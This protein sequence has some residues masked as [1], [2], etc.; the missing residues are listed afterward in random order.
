MGA[1][2]TTQFARA[3]VSAFEIIDGFFGKILRYIGKFYMPDCNQ[4]FKNLSFTYSTIS[5]TT[6]KNE[7]N[8]KRDRR[9]QARE[10]QNIG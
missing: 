6:S 1:N 7:P 10:K 3:R 4:K 9:L 5:G 8:R 2:C